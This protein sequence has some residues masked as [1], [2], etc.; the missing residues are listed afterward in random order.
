M[1]ILPEKYKIMK[2]RI[3]TF[4]LHVVQFY[5]WSNP[6]DFVLYTVKLEGI[7]F[8]LLYLILNSHN[9]FFCDKFQQRTNDNDN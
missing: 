8:H 1:T 7:N 3:K 9:V 5:Y 2:A 4:G 6:K